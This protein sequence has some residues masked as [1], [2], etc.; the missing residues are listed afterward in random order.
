MK[1]LAMLVLCAF[2][3]LVSGQRAVAEPRD[4]IDM[5]LERMAGTWYDEDGRAV[6]TI[7]Q[8][9]INGCEVIGWGSWVGSVESGGG[10]FRIKE[11]DGERALPIGWKIF[12][13]A[14]DYITLAFG[15]ALQRTLDPAG[16]ES[17][18]GIHFGMRLRAVQEV[19]GKGAELSEA[20]PY[21]AGDMSFSYGWH[22]A[23]KGLI[24]L[25][26]RGIVTGIVLLKG[27]RLHFDR[28]GLGADDSREEYA[29]AY[30][31][32]EIPEESSRIMVAGYPI[33]PGENLSFGHDGS[34]VMLS[35]YDN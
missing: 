10:E 1:G 28:S 2:V 21:R 19:L 22:Y 12:G 11:A 16:F 24:V 30:D 29:R 26:E 32:P 4:A 3:L 20:H 27:S 8:R 23:D 33:A 13:G 25:D 17:V 31:L 5:I 7:G 6:L 35:I 14:G 34:Y 15:Q 18:G 9:T